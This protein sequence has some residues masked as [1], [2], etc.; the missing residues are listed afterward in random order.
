MAGRMRI[1][2]SVVVDVDPET[3]SALNGSMN[4]SEVRED[5]KNYVW[6]NLLGLPMIEESGAGLTRA[7]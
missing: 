2:I 1:R 6:N 4:R 5:V 7:Q 3:W